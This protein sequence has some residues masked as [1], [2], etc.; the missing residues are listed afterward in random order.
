MKAT[1]FALKNRRIEDRIENQHYREIAEKKSCLGSKKPERNKILQ[2]THL[3][4]FA[5]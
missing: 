3:H 4:L 5:R 2:D 1:I